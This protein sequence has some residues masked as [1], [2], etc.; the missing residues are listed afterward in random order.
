VNALVVMFDSLNRRYLPPYGSTE[1]RAPNFTRLAQRS[2]RFD[3][4]YAGSLPC[5]PARREMHTARYNFLHRSWGPLEPF[6]DSIPQMLGAAGVTTHLATDHMHYWEDGGATYHTRF[7]TFS[8]IRGQQGDPWKGRVEEPAPG[9]DQRVRRTRTWR[10]DRVNRQYI[11]G[12]EAYPQTLTFDAGL[13]FVA[14]N[15][16]VGP[17]MVQIETFDPHEPFDSADA[18]R[19]LH[20]VTRAAEADYDWP[21]YQQVT[22]DSQLQDRVRRHY[23]ALVE[24]CDH[25]LGRVL[26]AMD[27]HGLWETTMLIVCTDHG[28]LLGEQGWWGKAVPP[29]YEETVH[30]PLFIWD[31]SS[32]QAAGTAVDQLVQT[33]DLGPTLLDLFGVAPGPDMQGRSL[34]ST[35]QLDTPVR[36]YAIFGSFGGHVAVTDG[37]HAYLRACARPDNQPLHEHTLMP[38]HM[39]GFFGPDRLA[40]AALVPGFSFTKGMPVLQTAG[41][42][43]GNPYQFGTLLFDLLEDP[44]Q[45]KPMLDDEIERRMATALRDLLLATEAPVSQFERLGLP[46]QGDLGAEHLQC[47]DQYAAAQAARRSPP[48][49]ASFPDSP[50]GI[51]STVGELLAEPRC[52]PIVLRHCQAFMDSGELGSVWAGATLYR[53]A[54]ALFGPL[55][56]R[57]LRMVAHELAAVDAGSPRRR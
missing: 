1:V 12:Y 47:R 7:G 13:E 18:F 43:V 50:W 37:R 41:T 3:R 29:W 51:H 20:G 27:E 5:M 44:E 23:R 22:E 48:P 57:A 34:R 31:P 8:L 45:D 16:A 39:R 35:I 52:A 56:W 6:D 28:F 38:T 49:P 10:Q 26:D 2:V 15:A 21:D 17:W 36:E 19:M 9:T 32:P 24:Q 53:A 54:A 40:D 46:R 30:T 25:S 33:I 11:H 14:D 42:T 55:P 4:C